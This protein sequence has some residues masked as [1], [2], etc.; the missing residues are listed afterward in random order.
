MATHTKKHHKN[1]E[2]L[3]WELVGCQGVEVWQTQTQIVRKK[4][5]NCEKKSKNCE[6]KNL[7]NSNCEK[8]PKLELWQNWKTQIVT[9][10]KNWNWDK[11]QKI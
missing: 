3:H 9:Q 11:T 2:K 8:T 6:R 7:Q 1:C 10:L 4:S 5:K